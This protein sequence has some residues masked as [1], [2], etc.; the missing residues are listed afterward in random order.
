MSLIDKDVGRTIQLI[1]TIT[2]SITTC[3]YC[4]TRISYFTSSHFM[5]TIVTNIEIFIIIHCQTKAVNIRDDYLPAY[6]ISKRPL[7]HASVSLVTY[8]KAT[9]LFVNYHIGWTIQLIISISCTISTSND[10]TTR[11]TTLPF[12]NTMIQVVSNIDCLIL[13]NV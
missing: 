3:H 13:I 4:P 9:I 6:T 12:D 8:N 2:L 7:H 11:C 10:L 5:F 1:M